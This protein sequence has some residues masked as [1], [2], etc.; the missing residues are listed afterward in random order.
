MPVAIILFILARRVIRNIKGAKYSTASIFMAPVIYLF[1]TL[2]LLVGLMAWQDIAILIAIAAGT[3]AGLELGKHSDIFEKDGKVLYRRSNEIM[4]LWIVGFVVRIGIDFLYNPSFAMIASGEPANAAA[5]AQ[6]AVYE[7][8]P[9]IFGADM[10]LALS[11]GLLLGEAVM[12]YRKH[13][14][15]YGK[16]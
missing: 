3:V 1:L 2:Y 8:S 10:L 13:G 11:A 9:V 12:L 7:T 15:R 14:S 4:I 6:L 5:T 16:G